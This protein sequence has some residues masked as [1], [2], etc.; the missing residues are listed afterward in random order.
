MEISIATQKTVAGLALGIDWYGL[1][2]AQI[3]F[4][5]YRIKNSVTSW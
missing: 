5:I 1:Q 3:E 4:V 2:N